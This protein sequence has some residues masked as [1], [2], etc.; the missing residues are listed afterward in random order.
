M[1][2]C[3]NISPP[4]IFRPRVV[5]GAL[6][7][8]RGATRRT[9]DSNLPT[10]IHAHSTHSSGR[11]PADNHRAG[12]QFAPLS[13]RSTNKRRSPRVALSERLAATPR[14][15]SPADPSH[16]SIRRRTRRPLPHVAQHGTR[17]AAV[18]F[19][20]RPDGGCS[21][22]PARRMTAD[23]GAGGGG[24]RASRVVFAFLVA[25][26]AAGTLWP[27]SVCGAAHCNY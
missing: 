2:P 15:S 6:V 23:D 21:Q 1:I 9:H 11:I 10:G 27:S 24:R 22:V 13:P 25:A 4:R 20:A 14:R 26:A 8:R 5:G 17:G 7:W 18:A 19:S 12:R 16:L 3:Q